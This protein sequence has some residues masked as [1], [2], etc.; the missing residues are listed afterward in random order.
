MYGTLLQTVKLAILSSGLNKHI[1][2]VGKDNFP[3]PTLS[4]TL[5]G[6]AHELYSGRGFFVLRTLPI[7]DY[8]RADVAIVYAGIS[9]R[10]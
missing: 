10:F 8:S 3:L 7:D 1:G 4:A 6:L 5:Q 2:Y 9:F